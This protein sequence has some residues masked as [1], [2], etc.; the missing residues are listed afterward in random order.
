LNQ[1]PPLSTPYCHYN[2]HNLQQILFDVNFTRWKWAITA[3]FGM[4]P[5]ALILSF[6]AVTFAI[7]PI[8]RWIRGKFQDSRGQYGSIKE[9][10]GLKSIGDE[11]GPSWDVDSV[12]GEKKLV[13]EEDGSD[14][15]T[16]GD[17]YDKDEAHSPADDT[18]AEPEAKAKD[19]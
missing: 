15:S 4:L 16:V 6:S 19:P 11:S 3:V 14:G 10:I 2:S 5:L 12:G 17:D 13:Q 1:H 9:R 7:I 18:A 8:I